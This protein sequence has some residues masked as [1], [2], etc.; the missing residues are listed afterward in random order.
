MG[1]LLKGI[2]YATEF[3]RGISVGVYL[4]LY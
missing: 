3:T 1:Q 4:P 2:A